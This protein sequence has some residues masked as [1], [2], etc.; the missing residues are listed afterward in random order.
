MFVEGSR[1]KN[2]RTLWVC[3]EN[4]WPQ[5]LPCRKECWRH[6]TGTD[7]CVHLMKL[8]VKKKPKQNTTLRSLSSDIVHPANYIENNC[9]SNTI[10]IVK[11]HRKSNS[12]G[13]QHKAALPGKRAS[14][15]TQSY[16]FST[17]FVY[18][19]FP[20]WGWI[21]SLFYRT[22]WTKC[23]LYIRWHAAPLKS[24]DCGGFSASGLHRQGLS[25][26]ARRHGFPV[27]AMC[28]S[29]VVWFSLRQTYCWNERTTKLVQK[30][31]SNST[32]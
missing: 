25:T 28:W 19:P 32:M 20:S 1:G 6:R 4:T 11:T 5:L 22:L 10:F 26:G 23:P 30:L 7:Y 15:W 17:L 18:S 31:I 12:Y 27:F 2:T 16:I 9:T 13:L 21:S 3:F 14:I 24:K 8:K 29:P